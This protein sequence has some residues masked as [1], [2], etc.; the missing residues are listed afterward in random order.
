MPVYKILKWFYNNRR[1]TT[2]MW[3]VSVTDDCVSSFVKD[4]YDYMTTNAEQILLPPKNIVE[5]QEAIKLYDHLIKDAPAKQ[6]TFPMLK[7]HFTILGMT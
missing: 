2:L 3:N 4:M 7:N 1:A 5:M 6:S